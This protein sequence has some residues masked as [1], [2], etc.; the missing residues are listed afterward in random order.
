LKV[1]FYKAAERE[2]DEAI[3]YYEQQMPGLGRRYR[4]AVKDA[5]D[6]IKQFPDAYSP[7]SYRTRRCLLSRFPYGI[8]YRPTQSE[9]IVVAVGHLH[10]RP[11]YWA[12]REQ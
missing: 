7:L 2:L 12:S 6:R 10:R 5:L 3:A 9:I 11:E 8:I 4:E 1:R